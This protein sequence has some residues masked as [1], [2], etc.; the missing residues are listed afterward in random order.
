MSGVEVQ[1]LGGQR[2]R[3]VGAAYLA[4]QCTGLAQIWRE[5][6]KEVGGM[7]RVALNNHSPR[8]VNPACRFAV[9]RS[10]SWQSYNSAF[11]GCTISISE[12]IRKLL[13]NHEKAVCARL[14]ER[15]RQRSYSLGRHV[16]WITCLAPGLHGLMC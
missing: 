12:C 15:I 7:D 6:A 8:D 3:L 11:L 4:S 13:R 5:G 16:R 1:V 9:G 14:S 10:S 2:Q